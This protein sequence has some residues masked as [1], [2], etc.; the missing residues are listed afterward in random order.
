MLRLQAIIYEPVLAIGV[1]IGIEITIY[2]ISDVT[3]ATEDSEK[4]LL[5]LYYTLA[6]KGIIMG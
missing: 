2:E 1:I 6:N 5:Y 3:T 4:T